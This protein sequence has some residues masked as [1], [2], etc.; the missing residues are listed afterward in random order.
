M[1]THDQKE[2]TMQPIIFHLG[3]DPG[4]KF[5]IRFKL[6]TSTLFIADF[7]RGGDEKMKVRGVSQE[8]VKR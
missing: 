7:Q 3:R 2:H 8:Q 4:E 5:P 1:T 6:K